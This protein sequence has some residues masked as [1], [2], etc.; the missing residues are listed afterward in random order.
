VDGG[1]IWTDSTRGEPNAITAQHQDHPSKTFT[2]PHEA[3]VVP[4]S[5][6]QGGGKIATSS[7]GSGSGSAKAAS[8]PGTTCGTQSEVGQFLYLEGHE[9]LM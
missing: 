4:Y 3:L 7:G 8:G 9:Y 2:F 5:T 1:T 6:G